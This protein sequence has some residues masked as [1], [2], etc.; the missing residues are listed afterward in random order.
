MKFFRGGEDG[1]DDGA[2]GGKSRLEALTEDGKL[3]NVVG[4][5]IHFIEILG[6]SKRNPCFRMGSVCDQIW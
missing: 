1:S 4:K 6:C 2:R 3:G 5:V